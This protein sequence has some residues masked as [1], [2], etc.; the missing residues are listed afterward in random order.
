MKR[1][2]VK[3]KPNSKHQSITN[4]DD[5]QWVVH[6]KSPPTEGKANAELIKLLADHFDVPKSHVSI[7]SGFSSRN[8]LIEIDLD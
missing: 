2:S 4:Q 3:V 6:L 1:L 8:K 7:K 5:Q